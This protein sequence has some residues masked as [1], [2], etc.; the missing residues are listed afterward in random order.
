MGGYRGLGLGKI[1]GSGVV[2]P[3]H[4]GF[5]GSLRGCY[6]PYRPELPIIFLSLLVGGWRGDEHERRRHRELTRERRQIVL[7]RG[8]V[9]LA[10]YFSVTGTAGIQAEEPALARTSPC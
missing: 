6:R 9:Y 2:L 1:P 7:P 8:V 3:L 5:T 10:G 4:G